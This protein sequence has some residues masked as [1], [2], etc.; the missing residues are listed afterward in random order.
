MADELVYETP[1]EE[2]L[3]VLARL[4]IAFDKPLDPERL[5]LYQAELA[6]VPMGLLE[7][8]ISRTI[9]NHVYS[10]VPSIGDVWRS[11]RAELGNP[12]DLDQAIQD[13]CE[14]Q[15]RKVVVDFSVPAER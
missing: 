7:L 10:S 6:S 3:S 1:L 13:W 14:R 5:Q 12:Y 2:W 8:A 11:V 9:R 15:W 4:W